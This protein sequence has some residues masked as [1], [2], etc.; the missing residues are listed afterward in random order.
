MQNF[1]PVNSLFFKY[2]SASYA[3]TIHDNSQVVTHQCV[4]STFPLLRY[5]VMRLGDGSGSLRSI[6]FHLTIWLTGRYREKWP[7]LV[8]QRRS[9]KGWEDSIIYDGIFLPPP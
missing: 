5:Y 9:S 8:S 6:M 2:Y 1:R 3:F 4:Y 7:S